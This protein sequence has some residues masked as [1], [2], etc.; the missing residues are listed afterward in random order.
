MGAM[1]KALALVIP[2]YKNEENIEHLVDILDKLNAD[3]Q[4]RLTVVFVIDG[5]P[6]LSGALLVDRQKDF[7]FASRIIF[8]SR[9]FGAFTAIRTGLE[10]SEGSF[11]A[12]MA[13]DLQ[14]PPELIIEMFS[15]LL[16]S[17]ADVV[18]GVRASRNDG[19]FR[20][21]LSHVFWA[22]YR[23]LVMPDVPKGGADVFACN[24]GVRDA[25]LSIREPNS[26]LIAQL[27]WL[28]F[29]RAFVSYERRKRRHG[30]S[31]W[32]FTMRVRYMMDSIFSFSDLPILIPL[33]AGLAG[34]VFSI[35]FSVYLI[36]AHFFDQIDVPGYVTLAVLIS[37]FG[38]V[39]MA[40]Q[41]VLGSYLWRTYENSKQRPLRL[42][43]RICDDFESRPS[44]CI[45]K[46]SC[47]LSETGVERLR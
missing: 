28:G 13:A 18:F 32:H 46:N 3:L 44:D 41:G 19:F 23:N 12:V 5:S 37:L 17:D 7:T 24:A 2:V 4:G 33:W 10:F 30:K 35:C 1:N 14:E 21:F 26:S 42:I 25:L 11:F 15:I 16:R 29:R 27:F 20:D 43:S 8:H 45:V 22:I 34:L 38:S 40:V 9:N 31:A 6:D 47:A 36:F 39:A